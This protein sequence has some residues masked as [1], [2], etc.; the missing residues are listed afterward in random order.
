MVLGGRRT[1]Q[2]VLLLTLDRW[3]RT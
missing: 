1:Y 2:N 3:K